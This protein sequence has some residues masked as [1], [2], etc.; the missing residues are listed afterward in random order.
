LVCVLQSFTDK[1][2]NLCKFQH[3]TIFQR[4]TQKTYAN[5]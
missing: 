1:P 3:S 2:K 4:Q 5:F